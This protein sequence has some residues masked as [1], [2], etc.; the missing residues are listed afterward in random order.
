M[1]LLCEK[2]AV[3][4]ELELIIARAKELHYLKDLTATLDCEIKC[5]NLIID[6]K[7]KMIFRKQQKISE[8]TTENINDSYLDKASQYGFK[9]TNTVSRK[10]KKNP[11]ES[12][13][14][15]DIQRH[16]RSET[17]AVGMM[18]H[19]ATQHDMQPA[20]N[21][22]IDSVVASFPSKKVIPLLLNSKL[23]CKI[24]NVVAK[25]WAAKYEQSDENILRSI[26]VF[27]SNNVLGKA[28]YIDMRKANR[29]APLSKVKPP[30]FIPYGKLAACINKIDI[31]ELEEFSPTLTYGLPDEDVKPGNFRCC[32]TYILRLAKCYLLVNKTRKDTR[33][34]TRLWNKF[35]CFVF[36]RWT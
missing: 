28:K 35:S 1:H 30:N 29:I 5:Q 13:L 31:G 25:Q 9:L 6:S 32:V 2:V 27:Y 15:Q 17:V 22:L 26:N 21:G 12:T 16:R 18:I 10:R 4:T 19:G 36:K 8:S 34:C 11:T 24:S 33:C 14:S 23:S 7:R 20:L 3:A